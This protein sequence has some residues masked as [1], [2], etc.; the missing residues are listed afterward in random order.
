MAKRQMTIPVILV[1]AL[2]FLWGFAHNLNPILIPHLKKACQLSDFQSAFIDSAFFIAYFAVALPAGYFMKRFGYKQGIVFGL[3]L[4]AVGAFLF[5]PAANTR[6]YGFFLGA[7]FVIASG[8]TF[9]ETA[10]NP[11]INALGNPE[12]ATQRLNLA[13]SFNGLAATLAPFIGG[14]FILSGKTLS[15]EDQ[16]S[17]SATDLAAYLQSEADAVKMPYM[18]IGVI[19]LLV[20]ILVSRTSLPEI[21]EEMQVDNGSAGGKSLWQNSNFLFGVIALFLYV[22]AQVGVVSFFIRFSEQV[23]GVQE[24][25]AANMLSVALLGF[26]LGRFVGTFL[27]RYVTPARMLAIFALLNV[28]FTLISA[29]VEGTFAVYA[30]V[31]VTFLMSI[32]FPTIFSLAIGGLGKNTKQG[33]SIL[34]MAIVGG[35][36]VPLA[37]GRLSDWFSMQ[38]AYG[39][40]AVCFAVVLLFALRNINSKVTQIAVVP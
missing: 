15:A 35:A 1:T 19:V 21:N 3:L 32:M 10:A 30:M 24:K 18:V 5:F 37:M 13:Q 33:S 29:G 17:M 6:E 8:L 14:Q 36:I 7:L 20:A 28:V 4:F 9:L 27:M 23:A 25:A 2:F 26:M 12:T 39:V 31:G 40:P 34:I 11:Y 22:G 16:V 38:S